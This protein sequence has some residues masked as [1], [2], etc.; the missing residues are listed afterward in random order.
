MVE[1]EDVKNDLA[2]LCR[3]FSRNGGNELVS[4][5][6]YVEDMKVSVRNDTRGMPWT[7]LP[8]ENTDIHPA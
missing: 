2:E 4:F 7:I 6:E 5:E 8:E 1:D 3:F